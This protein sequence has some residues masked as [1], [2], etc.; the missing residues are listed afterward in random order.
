MK[1]PTLWPAHPKP[2]AGELLSC[3]VARI[4]HAHGLK[5]QTFSQLVFGREYQLWNRDI[6]RGAPSWLLATLAAR[7]GTPMRVVRSLTIAAFRR[8][9]FWHWHSSGQLR[10]VAPLGIYHRTRRLHGLQFCPECLAGDD[11][12]YFRL[13][14]RAAV[15]TVCPEH[16]LI[17]RDRC[18]RC[19]A[20]VAFHR[21]EMGRPHRTITRPLCRCHRCSF[22]L[23][24]APQLRFSP[25][26]APAGDRAIAMARTLAD[27]DRTGLERGH[28]DVLHQLAKAMVSP[29]RS[30]R[31]LEFVRARLH[32]PRV[33]VPRGKYA[34]EQRGV[35]ERHH[36]LQLA[37]SLL[38][39]PSW[40]VEAWE[41]GDVSYADLSRDFPDSPEW[42]RR[43]I[44]PLNRRARTTRVTSA[45]IVQSQQQNR[46]ELLGCA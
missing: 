6:D 17:L 35:T 30:S 18:P 16:Q 23:R 10:W 8:R 9:L 4:A 14:W 26:S 32:A 43:L 25:Y 21:G 11:E 41:S 28:L 38:A 13:V 2:Y 34:F 39:T 3:W 5:I 27:R 12:P 44:A 36:V 42:Y 20:A 46:R 37:L 15:L 40:I 31:L 19:Y 7:T 24:R 45:K 29:R 22:D 1:R 33:L